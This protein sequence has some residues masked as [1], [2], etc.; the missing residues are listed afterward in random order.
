MQ[1]APAPPAMAG[2]VS[3]I[4]EFKVIRIDPG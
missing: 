1:K 2:R 3:T 4:I